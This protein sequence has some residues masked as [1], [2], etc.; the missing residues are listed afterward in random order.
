MLPNIEKL[1]ILAG[2][3]DDDRRYTNDNTGPYAW[4]KI[5]RWHNR[6]WAEANKK[7]N[8]KADVMDKIF[9]EEAEKEGKKD[10]KKMKRRTTIP[11]IIKEWIPAHVAHYYRI[12]DYIFSS[13]S[14]QTLPWKLVLNL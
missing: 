3:G 4:W 5:V 1:C 7:R 12:D 9:A 8:E 6:I 14:S 10:V 2:D 11:A 13:S